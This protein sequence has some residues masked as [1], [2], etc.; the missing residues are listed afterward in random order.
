MLKT[1]LVKNRFLPK[2][3]FAIGANRF[4]FIFDENT[5]ALKVATLKGRTVKGGRTIWSAD[6]KRPFKVTT[7]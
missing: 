5:K 4:Q 3:V 7:F 6:M 2:P 1:G